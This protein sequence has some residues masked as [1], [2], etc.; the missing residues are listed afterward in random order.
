MFFFFFCGSFLGIFC[1][2]FVWGFFVYFKNSNLFVT[3]LFLISLNSIRLARWLPCATQP[4][5]MSISHILH[6]FSLLQCYLQLKLFPL[7][8]ISIY[9]SHILTSRGIDF[10]IFWTWW[11]LFCLFWFFSSP[12][13]WFK[14]FLLHSVYKMPDNPIVL[15]PEIVI[16][17][18]IY[19][20]R[21]AKAMSPCYHTTYLSV[22]KSWRENKLNK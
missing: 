2:L 17:L 5:G 13:S 3:V 1:Y 6:Y 20:A 19:T 18:V 11:V 15:I 22:V 9:L 4:R 14:S 8:V 12:F 16:A 21:K 10:C 7:N